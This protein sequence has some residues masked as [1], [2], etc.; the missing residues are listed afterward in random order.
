MKAFLAA[1]VEGLTVV[2]RTQAALD[3][4]GLGDRVL[5]VCGDVSVEETA[6]NYTTA[7]VEKWGRVDIVVLNAGVEGK[8]HMLHETPLEEYDKVMAVNA[9]GGTFSTRPG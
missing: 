3:A 2:D 7:T 5:T 1:G 4:L 8:W 9:R 6:E